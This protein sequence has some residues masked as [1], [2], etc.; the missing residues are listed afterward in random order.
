[1][2]LITLRLFV[3]SSPTSPSPL[4]APLTNK[5]FS[6][7]KEIPAPSNLGSTEYSTLSSPVSSLTLLSK[8][9]KSA[10]L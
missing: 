4:V 8:S 10:S 1:M 2:V 3:I 9:L 6:Y 5:S 7:I